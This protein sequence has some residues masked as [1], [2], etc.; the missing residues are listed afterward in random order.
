M[1]RS[2]GVCGILVVGSLSGCDGVNIDLG[3]LGEIIDIIGN[4]NDNAGGNANDN[5]PSPEPVTFNNVELTPFATNTDGAGGMAINPFNNELY[6]VNRNGLFGPIEEGDDVSTMTPIG[7]TNL[8]DANLFDAPR[9]NFVLAITEQGEFWIGSSCCGTLAVVPAEGGDAQPFE[10]LLEGNPPANI[11]PETMVIAPA[12]VNLPGVSPG[13]LLVS[14]ETTFSKLAAIK[15]TGDRSVTQVDNPSGTN[16]Q[17]HHIAFGLDGTLYTSRS[18][19]GATILGLQTVT[20]DGSPTGLP[21]TLN[22]AA[23]SFVVL[24]NDD[25]V[26]RGAFTTNAGQFVEGVHLYSAADESVTPGMEIPPEEAS[27]DDEML[28]APD[29][30]ILLSLPARN[31]IV[32]VTD[33]RE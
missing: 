14:A 26:L 7:A 30:R 6:V 5:G 16:R 25:L 10:G 1:I 11:F 2:L 24:D 22:L 9:D 3:D 31:E 18:V 4:E 32:V 29:G 20:S 12:N 19:G 15:V 17:G 33:V 21:G 27:E 13:D 8:A 28:I 23:D